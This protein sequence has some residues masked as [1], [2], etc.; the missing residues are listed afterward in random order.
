MMMMMAMMV[1]IIINRG[2]PTFFFQSQDEFKTKESEFVHF[3]PIINEG[4][5]A[6]SLFPLTKR[7]LNIYWKAPVEFATM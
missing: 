5:M 6:K 2:H 1:L 7:Q 4:L 3:G